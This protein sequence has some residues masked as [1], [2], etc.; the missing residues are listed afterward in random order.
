MFISYLIVFIYRY[1]NGDLYGLYYDLH[2]LQRPFIINLLYLTQFFNWFLIS[3]C[4]YNYFRTKSKF[5][6][7]VVITISST[8]IFQA[9]VS[10]GKGKLV[11]LVL[12]LSSIYWFINNKIPKIAV[13]LSSFFVIVFSYYSYTARNIAYNE[14][15]STNLSVIDNTIFVANSVF[16]EFNELDEFIKETTIPIF[17]RFNALDGLILCQKRK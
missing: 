2:D 16:N 12:L 17:N 7:F 15:R 13:I 3:Y 1:L 14:V 9:I 8:I 6:L 5:G 11:I 10:T 4:A